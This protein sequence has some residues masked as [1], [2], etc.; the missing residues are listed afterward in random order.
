MKITVT[1]V[2]KLLTK[3]F[4]NTWA[5]A[6]DENCLNYVEKMKEFIFG[7]ETLKIAY[8][9]GLDI[10]TLAFIK[11]APFNDV[12]YKKVEM[13]PENKKEPV[14]LGLLVNAMYRGR[15]V[16]LVNLYRQCGQIKVSEPHANSQVICFSIHSIQLSLHLS[17][18][19]S[20]Q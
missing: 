4:P 8:D 3:L 12:Y 13:L 11:D 14:M 15:P 5:I 1:A 7:R 6:D 18:H 19:L 16:R 10:F 2:P 20:V 17:T 9:M